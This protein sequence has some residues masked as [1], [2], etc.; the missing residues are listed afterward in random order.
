M[1]TVA[2]TQVMWVICSEQ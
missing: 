1:P 2:T